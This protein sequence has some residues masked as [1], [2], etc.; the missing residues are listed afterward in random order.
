MLRRTA[1]VACVL[2][3][4]ISAQPR[5][6]NAK[7]TLIA[8]HQL[9][10]SFESWLKLTDLYRLSACEE[11][12]RRRRD[13]ENCRRMRLIQSKGTGMPQ[14]YDSQNGRFDWEFANGIL[15]QVTVTHYDDTPRQIE[16]LT[17]A[18]GKPRNLKTVKYRNAFG[19]SWDCVQADWAMSDGVMIQANE[20]IITTGPLARVLEVAFIS[21]EAH[22]RLKAQ[23]PAPNPYR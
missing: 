16:F 6:Q 3:T 19:G 4:T 8:G 18:Y 11:G 10:E 23:P 5:G 2:C 9:S 12:P 22:D 1:A 21:K 15:E 7:P 17:E 14:T 13:I 20:R